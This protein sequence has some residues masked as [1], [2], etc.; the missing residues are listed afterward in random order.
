MSQ[1]QQPQFDPKNMILAVALS[2]AIVF[3]WQYFYAG[4]AA[5]KAEQQVTVQQQQTAQVATDAAASVQDAA[6]VLASTQ[7]VKL[8]TPLLSGS[9]NLKGARIDDLRLT[10]YRETTAP[11]SPATTL[12]APAGTANAYFVEHA[13]LKPTDTTLQVPTSD[14]VWT[15][16]EGVTLTPDKPLTLT[17]DNGT[18][19][20]FERIIS[21]NDSYLFTVKQT[22]TNSGSAAVL[23]SPFARVQRDDAPKALGTWTFY[24]GPLGVLNS[25]LQEH[26]YSEL[27]SAYEKNQGKDGSSFTTDSL[28]GWVGFTDKYW[29]TVVIPDTQ[30]KVTADYEYVPL[31]GRDGYQTD[32][33]V[34]EPISVPAGGSATYT[35]H[36]YAGAK[37]VG[38]IN[39][40]AASEKIDKFDLMID[41]GWFRPI[42]QLMFW[43]LSSINGIVGNFGVSI[44][45]V[46]VAVKAVLFPLANKSYASMSKMKNLKPQ[47]D[48]IKEKYPDDKT[49]Q[50]QETMELYKREK[51]NP[52]AG[53][54]PIFIQIPVFFSL[55]KV[56]YTTIEL[57]QA[58]FFGWIHDLSV[59]D[60]TSIFN[61][62]GLIP[63]HPPMAMMIGFWPLL[64]GITMW[65]QM[66]LN[67]TP[68]DPVQAQMFNWM[69][70]IF[71]YSMAAFPAG[72]TIYWA[73]SNFLSII[74]QSYIMK[75]HGT[76]INILGNIANSIPFLKKK[77]VAT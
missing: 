8:E 37:V 50:Q 66:R 63:W 4:P 15:A 58:P 75:K 6:T 40:I 44:L 56:I 9:I 26:K 10:K 22:F 54:L 48:L 62:F 47:M 12:L 49:K 42:T 70:V 2:M 57:R 20:K 45:I 14:T 25:S 11:S 19:L 29:S 51:V 65:V 33:R 72:L 16:P 13:F 28:G 30:T 18:G 61:L 76:E 71:T 3:G 68:P 32:Y 21:V 69:P 35:D 17:W 73:W 59:S 64:M 34:A 38:T 23:V 27:K 67:P 41:W 43:L 39:A 5:K 53:C 31:P 46:T 7:R 24:E 74:Q 36:V 55:Y 60:P 52:M 77:P 1:S